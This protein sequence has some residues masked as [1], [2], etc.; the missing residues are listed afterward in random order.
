MMAHAHTIGRVFTPLAWAK[1]LSKKSGAYDAWRSGASVLD[2]TC[3]DGVFLEALIAMHLQQET[4]VSSEMLSRLH[5]IEIVQSDKEA[6]LRRMR[7]RY[8][9]EFPTDNFLCLNILDEKAD[10]KC[11]FLIGNPPWSNFADLPK[12]AKGN[13]AESFI[14]HG[15]VKNKKDVLLGKSRADLCALV[16]KK[17]IDVNLFPNGRASFFAPLSILFNDGANEE[18]RP[19]PDSSHG[20]SITTVWDFEGNG[21]FDGVATRYGV[22]NCAKNTRQKWPVQTWV[23]VD[24]EWSEQSSTSCDLKTGGWI[25]HDKGQS[26]MS[27][28]RIVAT[29]ENKPRQG[30]NTCGANDVFIFSRTSQG[31][32]DKNGN[33]VDLEADLQFPLIDRSIFQTGVTDPDEAEKWILIPHESTTGKCLSREELSKFPKSE[34]YLLQHEKRLRNRKGTI[35]RAS[36]SKERWWSLLGVGRYSFLQYKVAWEALGKRAF[37]PVL[38]DGR[39]QGNQAMHAFCPCNSKEEGINIRNALAEGEVEAWLKSFSMGGTCNWAQPGKVAKIFDFER[40][41]L[42]LL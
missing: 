25:R 17:T 35:I 29:L 18:F 16:I 33:I 7:E 5:G 3:G 38:I 9:V 34:H 20:Y 26:A 1:W 24:G 30:V 21:V 8:S 13:W 23:E 37:R 10:I 14:K 36:I 22:I 19:H 12:C 40:E 6:F 4:C 11:D 31:L 32:A 39:W 15:L 42:T 41:Q 27:A 2:P 28:P